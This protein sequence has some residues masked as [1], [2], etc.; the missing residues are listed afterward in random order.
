MMKLRRG[1]VELQ[2]AAERKIVDTIGERLDPQAA[3]I[4]TFVAAGHPYRAS[5]TLDVET[6]VRKIVFVWRKFGTMKSAPTPTSRS[7]F[8]E[9]TVRHS[10]SAVATPT[11]TPPTC[12]TF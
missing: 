2:P 9:S 8:H 10:G 5:V 7:R 3:T 4:K 12:F 1:I 11:A 6:N